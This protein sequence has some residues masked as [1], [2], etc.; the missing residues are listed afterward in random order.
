MSTGNFG[1]GNFKGKE[2]KIRSTLIHLGIGIS[3]NFFVKIEL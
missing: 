2:K 3:G 1:E